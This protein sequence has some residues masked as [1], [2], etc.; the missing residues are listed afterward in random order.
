[1][2]TR[3]SLSAPPPPPQADMALQLCFTSCPRRRLGESQA[4][5]S[6][7]IA[8]A[9]FGRFSM[10]PP[11]FAIPLPLRAA[12]EAPRGCWRSVHRCNYICPGTGRDTAQLPAAHVHARPPRQPPRWIA[13]NQHNTALAVVAAGCWRR[14]DWV[15]GDEHSAG[16]WWRPQGRARALISLPHQIEDPVVRRSVQGSPS[17]SSR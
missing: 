5:A 3:M 4:D 11:D 16:G 17:L 8:I 10:T 9:R 2:C 13:I 15:A 14:R 6:S 1:M 12:Q 7:T